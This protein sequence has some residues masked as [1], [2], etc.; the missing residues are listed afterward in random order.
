M[1]VRSREAGGDASVMLDLKRAREEQDEIIGEF[2]EALNELTFNSKPIILSLTMIAEEYKAFAPQIASLIS[3]RIHSVCISLLFFFF[4]F[5]FPPALTPLILQK[6][7]AN[8]RLPLVYLVDSLCKSVADPYRAIFEQY[9]DTIFITTYEMASEP[10]RS[11]LRHLL[12]TWADVFGAKVLGPITARLYPPRPPSPHP[13]APALSYPAPYLPP[14]PPNNTFGPVYFAAP[15]AAPQ[16]TGKDILAALYR[17]GLYL[18][19]DCGARIKNRQDYDTHLAGH[20]AAHIPQ[21]DSRG[22]PVRMSRGWM[23]PAEYIVSNTALWPLLDKNK[24]LAES[25]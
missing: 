15:P 20:R 14:A 23:P 2:G 25:L 5:Y 13:P 12:G 8:Q 19:K 11:S 4:F 18:C 22:K 7:D 3:Q 9:I 24:V 6:E 10:V 21:K 1:S 17:K 16:P